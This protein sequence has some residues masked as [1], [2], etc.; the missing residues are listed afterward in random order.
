MDQPFTDE[1]GGNLLH[2]LTFTQKGTSF[3]EARYNF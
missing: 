2:N 3:K 1:D